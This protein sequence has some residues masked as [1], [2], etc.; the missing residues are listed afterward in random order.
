MVQICQGG[1][2]WEVLSYKMDLEEP[3]GAIVIAIALKKKNDASMRTSHTEIMNTLVGLCKPSP[4]AMDGHVPFEP[5]RDKMIEYYGAAVDHPDFMNAFQVVLD[6]GGHES[7][8]LA[9]LHRVCEPEGEE[10]S[11]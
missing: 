11:V 1:I 2:A 5:I 10:I 9:D 3:E 6:A 8:H 7:P 4:D